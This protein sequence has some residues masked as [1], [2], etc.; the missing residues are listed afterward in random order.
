MPRPRQVA[1]GKVTPEQAYEAAIKLAIKKKKPY[2][3]VAKH[4]FGLT[5]HREWMI[6]YEQGP[7]GKPIIVVDDI[8]KVKKARKLKKM[9]ERSWAEGHYV[10]GSR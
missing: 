5:D 4:E 6:T 10:A 7:T 9:L 8:A 2:R 1:M 3:L